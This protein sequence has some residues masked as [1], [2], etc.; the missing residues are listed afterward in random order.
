MIVIFRTHGED[1]ERFSN[2][3]REAQPEIMN[4]GCRR[5][6]AYRNRKHPQDWVMFQEWP[7][8]ATFDQFAQ[9]TGPE[10]DRKAGVRWSDVSTWIESAEGT[11]VPPASPAS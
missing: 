5:I 9:S 1:W 8:K 4:Q 2:T 10:L 7:D 11:Q 3:L 6:E